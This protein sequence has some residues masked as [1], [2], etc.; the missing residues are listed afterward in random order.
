MKCRSCLLTAPGGL[1]EIQRGMWIK[2][3]E[4]ILLIGIMSRYPEK[5]IDISFNRNR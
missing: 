4:I 2:G 1:L 3:I 5:S